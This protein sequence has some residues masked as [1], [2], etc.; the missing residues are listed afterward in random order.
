MTL[1]IFFPYFADIFNFSWLCCLKSR[2]IYRFVWTM[3]MQMEA[4]SSSQKIQAPP[5]ITPI[6]FV[7]RFNFN[8]RPLI[9]RPEYWCFRM[10][11][12]VTWDHWTPGEMVEKTAWEDSEGHICL[13][14]NIAQSILLLGENKRA[15]LRFYLSVLFTLL[16]IPD[17]R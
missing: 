17:H 9:F 6:A 7:F 4:D 16:A 11:F 8:F 5:P 14:Q 3:K 15:C 12:G 13:F 2:T 1:H 10:G